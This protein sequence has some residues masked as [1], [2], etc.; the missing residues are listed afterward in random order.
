MELSAFPWNDTDGEKSKFTSF[1]DMPEAMQR[2]VCK[3]S[4]DKS[5]SLSPRLGRLNL[6][7]QWQPH[8]ELHPADV[9]SLFY[10]NIQ[11]SSP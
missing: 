9:M 4:P 3:I 2:V 6:Q 10:F 1:Q 11:R 5:E 8:I 7:Q